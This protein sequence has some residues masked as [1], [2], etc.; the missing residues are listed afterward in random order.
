M[1]SFIQRVVVLLAL[2]AA[3]AACGP[4][5][6]SVA[7]LADQLWEYSLDHPDGF[8]LEIGSM[9]EAAEG[10]AVAYAATQGSH[11]RNSL[12]SVIRHAYRHDGYIG[13]WLD[14]GSGLYYFDSVRLFPENQLQEALTFAYLNGQLAVYI[15]ST[16][17]EISLQPSPA[18]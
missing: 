3:L 5:R 6:G 17:E 10:I 1:R 8:T 16:G 13:G 12:P 9:T 18:F 11:S 4:A 15:L 2:G 14:T 7:S